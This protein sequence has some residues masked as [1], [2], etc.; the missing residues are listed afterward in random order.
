MAAASLI[1]PER[2]SSRIESRCA[3]TSDVVDEPKQGTLGLVGPL[4]VGQ[5]ECGRLQ[6]VHSG[7]NV[8]DV[9]AVT[10]GQVER[11]EFRPDLGRL[12]LIP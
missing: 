1:R 2:A 3:V 4:E 10:F 6:A 8:R 5:Q 12:Q 11:V 7:C 9:T